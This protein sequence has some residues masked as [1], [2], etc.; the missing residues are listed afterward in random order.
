MLEA[1]QSRG[2]R[3]NIPALDEDEDEDDDASMTSNYFWSPRSQTHPR[4]WFEPITKPQEAGLKLLRSGDF[5]RLAAKKQS[6]IRR[7]LKQ[8]EMGLKGRGKGFYKEDF[9]RVNYIFQLLCIAH[10]IF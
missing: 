6:N 9:S 5:G 10:F 4:K 8:R 7:L 3:A 1:A 2:F